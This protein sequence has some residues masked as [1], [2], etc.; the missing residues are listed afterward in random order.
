MLQDCHSKG[1]F[2]TILFPIVYA[3]IMYETLLY[4]HKVSCKMMTGM[5]EPG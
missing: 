4:S 1:G 3:W 2:R 5:G